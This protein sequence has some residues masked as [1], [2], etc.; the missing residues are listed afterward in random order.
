MFCHYVVV[1]VVADG[2]DYVDIGVMTDN[3]SS[4]QNAVSYYLFPFD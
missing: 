2:S 1:V 3:L 4:S